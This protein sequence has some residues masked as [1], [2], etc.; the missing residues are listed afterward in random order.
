MAIGYRRL[1]KAARCR[2]RVTGRAFNGYAWLAPSGCLLPQIA[3]RFD[4][5]RKTFRVVPILL[6]KSLSTLPHTRRAAPNRILVL[7]S[8][9]RGI[10]FLTT[11]P[12]EMAF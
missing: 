8:L 12:Q 1:W 2:N 7:V 3:D 5:M 10:A 6:Q 9:I 11:S 4:A